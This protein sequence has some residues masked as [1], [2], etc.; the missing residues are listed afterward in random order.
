M[1]V[2]EN[3]ALVY[4]GGPAL[5]MTSLADVLVRAGAVRALE[6]DINTD[7]VQYSIFNAPLGAAV[8]GGSGKSLL[9]TM[10]GPPSRY[11]TTWWN[12]DFFTVSLRSAA[13]TVTT[14]SQP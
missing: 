8:N 6:L 14:T 3:G 4:A 13:T 7:W 9:S 1:G 11:F 10:V 12:R 5:T 2:T